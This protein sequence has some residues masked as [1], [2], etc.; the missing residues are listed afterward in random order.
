MECDDHAYQN[1][2]DEMPE[3]N[4][5]RQRLILAND[6]RKVEETEHADR[7][8]ISVG[9]RPAEYGRDESKDVERVLRPERDALLDGSMDASG[10]GTPKARRLTSRTTMTIR[11]SAPSASWKL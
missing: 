3:D 6:G 9:T 5:V 8:A 2:A 10:A 1:P 4:A 11:T 7:I